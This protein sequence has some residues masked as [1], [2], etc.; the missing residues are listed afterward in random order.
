MSSVPDSPGIRVAV[1]GFWHVHAGD[2][3]NAVLAHPDTELVA[4]WD[5]DPERGRAGADQFGVEFAADLDAL[6][7]RDDIDAVTVT[8]ATRPHRDVM[9]AAA[10][11]GKHI[12]TEKVLAPTL[13]E[14]AEILAAVRENGVQLEVSLPRL[15]EATTVTAL[16]ALE[17]GRLGRLTYARIRLA[18]D[19]ALAGWLPERFFD[20][21]DAIGGALTDLGCHPVYLAQR[22]LGARPESVTAAY[23][24]VTGR[25]LEDNAVVTATYPD[26]A[27]AVIEA[28]NVTVPGAFAFELRGTEG[29]LLFGFGGE[30]LLAKG[31]HFD[32]ENWTE[33]PLLDAADG[34]FARWVHAIRTG[35]PDAANLDAAVEL[36]RLVVAAN[37][38]AATGTTVRL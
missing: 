10:R 12:F 11:A 30:R 9:V 18:H 22:F 24:S 23:T 27:I 38:A 36:T 19:G 20:E 8:T 31:P 13:D 1:L 17:Q 25:A 15:Y 37:E 26:G 29:T 34:P 35:T 21:H 7:A 32:P 5:D 6:L 2:Y 16:D 4:V 33:L 3:A 28:S 14:T